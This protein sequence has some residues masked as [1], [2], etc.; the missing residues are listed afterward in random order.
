MWALPFSWDSSRYVVFPDCRA[1]AADT[2]HPSPKDPGRPE[3]PT[4]IDSKLMVTTDNAPSRP[5]IRARCGVRRAGG[6]GWLPYGTGRY[7]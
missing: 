6:R 1:C 4:S 5:A 2:A 3:R 7:G